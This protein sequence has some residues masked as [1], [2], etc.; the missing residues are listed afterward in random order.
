VFED[1]VFFGNGW[2][3][4]THCFGQYIQGDRLVLD[5]EP[6]QI[7]VGYRELQLC[8]L[9]LDLGVFENLGL[10]LC[11]LAETPANQHGIVSC[12]IPVDPS[13]RNRNHVALSLDN[14]KELD[15][16]RDKPLYTFEDCPWNLVVVSLQQL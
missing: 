9:L 10:H 12:H 7:Q 5:I 8:Q 3:A 2:H 13:R 16:F 15:V 14:S 4:D 11:L 6:L 1:L